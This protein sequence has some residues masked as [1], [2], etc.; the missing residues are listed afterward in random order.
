MKGEVHIWLYCPI[1]T[2]QW[3]YTHSAMSMRVN[4]ILQDLFR[5][6]PRQHCRLTICIEF[7][8]LTNSDSIRQQDPNIYS[9]TEARCLVQ[10]PHLTIFSMPKYAPQILY[11]VYLAVFGLK[12]YG[13]PDRKYPFLTTSLVYTFYICKK[14]LTCAFGCKRE[15]IYWLVETKRIL[16]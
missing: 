1:D 4:C 13:Q 12:A 6:T 2:L 14:M 16:C 10:T 11:L 9:D 15:D 5:D 3:G 7:D 8:D